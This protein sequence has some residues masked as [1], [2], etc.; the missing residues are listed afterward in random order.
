M[1]TALPKFTPAALALAALAAPA[2]AQTDAMP[3]TMPS[4]M[5][6][7]TAASMPALMPVPP[8]PAMDA[9]PIDAG[10]IRALRDRV[11]PSLVAVE[12]TYD[13]EVGRQVLAGEGF[14]V[15]ADGVVALSMVLTPEQLPDVQLTNFKI[16][17]PGD[18]ERK[19]DA[20]FQGRDPRSALS[21]V[22]VADADRGKYAWRPVELSGDS[23]KVGDRVVSVGILPESA[24]YGTY[25]S[26]P[27]VS[28]MLRGPIPQTLVT[29][30]GL[31]G[32][33][34]LVFNSVGEVEGMV[35]FQPQFQPGSLPFLNSPAG[36][37]GALVN[38]ARTYIPT[39][40]FADSVKS[41]PTPASPAR[42]SDIGIR[43]SSGLSKDLSEYYGLVGKP[44]IEVGDVIPDMPAAKAGLKSGDVV[45]TLDGEPLERGDEPDELPAILSRT[46]MR[47]PV[48]STVTFGVMRDKDQPL[49]QIKVQLDER[50]KQAN[51]AARYY[52]KE[53]GFSARE[54]VFDDK[55]E[56]K[57]DPK[58]Q[59][60]VVA[61]VK[62]G[63]S[64]QTA[65]LQ[66]GDV[67]TRVNQTAIEGLKQFETDLKQVR[68]DKPSDAVVLEVIRG[69]NTQ[70]V[71]VEPPQK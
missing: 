6:A 50:P 25:V 57:L 17:I 55:Y 2:L 33:G 26:A 44:A 51:V 71:R 11:K 20:T 52:A 28:A 35:Q 29:A 23:A 66:V 45:V 67:I 62:P 54:L 40:F 30:E 21:F 47:M 70:I 37:I 19:L 63:S 9:G 58:T 56:N 16:I 8:L 3:S 49:Q 38:P 18:E 14:V 59:G 34:S 31:C 10:R 46:L 64:A 68:K 60:V 15:S 13:G 43:Q 69:A 22:K 36:N 5:P 39:S 53:L 12:Y 61:F 41:P 65:Q 42:L 4:T 27:T 24:G 1:E 48:G 32:V 7:T